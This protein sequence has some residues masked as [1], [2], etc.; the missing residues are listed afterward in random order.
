MNNFITPFKLNPA[1][2][3]ITGLLAVILCLMKPTTAEARQL[4]ADVVAIDQFWEYNRFGSFNPAGMMYALRRDVV[5][6]GTGLPEN[7][8]PGFVKLREDKR[9]RPLVLRANVGDTLTVNFTNLL[10][11]DRRR[12]RPG[13]PRVNNDFPNVQPGFLRN[14]SPRTRSASMVTNAVT[15]LGDTGIVSI[16]PNESTVY[17]WQCEREGAFLIWDNGSPSGG[18]GLGGSLALGL[19]GALICEP[20]GSTWYRSQVTQE[21]M[22][23]ARAQADAPNFINYNAVDV[24]GNPI[25]N[26]LKGNEIIHSDLNAI[27]VNDEI[28]DGWD[29]NSEGTFREFT[30][31]FHD[32]IKAVQAFDALNAEHMAGVRDGF[33]INYGA[34]G[35]GP[36]I[37]ANRAGIGPAANCVDCAYEE[38]FLTS[39]ANGD[40]ALL[41][42]YPDDPSNVHH[43]YLNDNVKFRNLHAGPKETHIFHLH[44]HQWLGTIDGDNSTY[45]DSQTIAPFQAFAY[46]ILYGGSGNRNRTAGDSIFHCHLYPHFAQGMWSLWRVHDVFED[47]S[48]M[49]PDGELGPGTDPL[50]GIADGGTPSPAVIPVPAQGMAPMP[51]YGENGMPGYPFYIAAEA[52]HRPPQAPMDLVPGKDGG[53]PRHRMADGDVFADRAVHPDPIGSGDFGVDLFRANLEILPSIGT[54]LEQSA[55]AFHANAIGHSTVTPEGDAAIFEVNGLPPAAGAPYADPCPP[56]SSLREYDV[57][58]IQLDLVVNAAGWHD[59][60]AR[61]NVLDSDVPQFE[62]QTTVADPFFFRAHSGDCIEFRHTNRTPRQLELDDFQVETPTDTI[63]QHIH[64]VKFDVTSSDGSANGFN[65][66]DGTF[67]F[68]AVIERIEISHA[69]G[70]SA[71]NFDGTPLEHPLEVE[72]GGYQT[73]TQRWWADPLLNRIGQDRTMRTVFTHDH[74]A[75]SSIQQHGFYSGLVIEPAG[76]TWL[77]P[78]GTPLTSGVGTQ[79]MIVDSLDA[80]THPDHREFMVEYQDFALLYDDPQ[81]S[82]VQPRTDRP[83]FRPEFGNP[84]DPP[85]FP[86]AISKAHHDP[87]LINYKHE[88]IPLRVFEFNN[89]GT[90]IGPKAGDS[91]DMAHVFDSNV[92]GDPFTEIFRALEGDRVQ[93]RVLQGAQEVQH[94]FTVNGLKWRREIS[95]P[96]SPYVAVQEMGISEHFEADIPLTNQVGNFA[97]YLYH[98]GTTGA[99]WNGGWGIMRSY[100]DARLVP[101]LAPLPGKSGTG[102]RIANRREFTGTCPRVAPRKFFSIEAWAAKDLLPGG[103][104]VYNER[105]GIA[106]A[107]GLMFILAEDRQSYQNGDITDIEPLVIRANAGDCIFVDLTN[108]LPAVMPD[109]IDTLPAGSVFDPLVDGDAIL[110]K[111]TTVRADDFRPSNKVSLHPTL[112]SYDVSSNDGSNVGVN[113]RQTAAPGETVRYQW[114]AGTL[115]LEEGVDRFGRP[116]H[117]LRAKAEPFGV[118]PLRS[119]GDVIK[120]G[121]QGL[122]G[123]MVIEPAGATWTDDAGNPI[124]RGTVARVSVPGEEPFKEFVVLYQ[125]GLNL[126]WNGQGIPDCP[127]CDDHY[128]TGENGLNYRSEPHWARL[129]QPPST[130]LLDTIYPTDWALGPI[131]TPLFTASTGERIIF[132]VVQPEG[133]ARQHTFNVMGHDYLDQGLPDFLSPGSTLITPG[134]AKNAEVIGGAKEGVWLYRE[135]PAQMY[136]GGIWGRFEVSAPG[137]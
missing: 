127:V 105:E 2:F 122:I 99:L 98:L 44:A 87:Y 55:M 92:H 129:N 113:V 24:A 133:R 65:Y 121:S 124:N 37:M 91:G 115:S 25:L 10:T 34:S 88:P 111:I 12:L 35:L 40:P 53:L 104:I 48:R 119:Y 57:S 110:P 95:N 54:P 3:L 28:D 19:F 130:D 67:S 13:A 85:H 83:A 45:L 43:S 79:A 32:E 97:D 46:D 42:Q 22:D 84:V 136:A 21:E 75:P 108:M 1:L 38:F 56:G 52:G 68:E 112:L 51:T 20:E 96:D 14:D 73:T 69:I 134:V 29:V 58:A 61:I 116:A 106:D 49:L 27:I 41:T 4:T 66:E 125:D 18:E 11:P 78:D 100:S 120:Q 47:G 135:G 33:A 123:A 107:T 16:M 8:T 71:V 132:R 86:E 137:P 50:T 109:A 76:S 126:R 62:G 128:D 6:K 101:D 89:D 102:I 80:V 31:I 5:N 103:A 118:L 72:G 15:S 23:E 90:L 77:K 94:A 39:W 93:W 114:Y 59:P 64:L 26:I 117:N 9:P 82:T 17:T 74:F 131:E 81:N 63:G 60:Q 36:M 70:G 7:L 30:V